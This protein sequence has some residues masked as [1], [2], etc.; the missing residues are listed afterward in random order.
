MC[1]TKKF[2][3]IIFACLII[4]SSTSV[5]CFASSEQPI[6]N[7]VETDFDGYV[8]IKKIHDR[9]LNII[10][11]GK[12]LSDKEKL[13]EITEVLGFEKVQKVD[14]FN[15][16]VDDFENIGDIVTYTK[17]CVTDS[18]GNSK[19][20]SKERCL[21]MIENDKNEEKQLENVDS[22]T[23]YAARAVSSN[24]GCEDIT[25]NI[26]SGSNTLPEN[27]YM[28]ISTMII[29]K[30]NEARGTYNFISTY[31]WLREPA[32]RYVDAIS[33]YSS[34]IQWLDDPSN[35]SSTL[36]YN[37]KTRANGVDIT[38]PMVIEKSS[39][40][41]ISKSGVF[42]SYEMPKDV[43]LVSGTSFVK[44]K[45]EDIT[46]LMTAKGWV[47]LYNETDQVLD[48]N[49]KYVH[50]ANKRLFKDITFDISAA[51]LGVSVTAGAK[52][53]IEYNNY[54][55]WKYIDHANL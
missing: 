2:L 3:S 32:D 5:V 21:N 30:K 40:D 10:K 27:D 54:C 38:E 53:D 52:E 24:G 16:L 29:Y 48:V 23:T 34:S 25:E 39:P 8:E 18:S 9:D 51:G 26:K 20:V 45:Q 31:T 22:A 37:Q 19:I 49:A 28:E 6:E 42:Y 35:F 15:E 47:T 41:K 11:R 46:F 43:H 4:L 14:I 44:V 17:Y 7:F 1:K 50:V 33:L 13:S 12:R 55:A 36:L